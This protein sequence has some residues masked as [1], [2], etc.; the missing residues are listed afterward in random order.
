M[1]NGFY[2]PILKA[3]YGEFLA[4]SQLTPDIRKHI[5]PLLEITPK[6]W[7][8]EGKKKALSMEEHLVKI[9]LKF[10][11]YWP[12]D[13][14]FIDTALIC[15]EQADSSSCIEYLYKRF[16]ERGLRPIPVVALTSPAG[17]LA[18][19]QALRQKYTINDCALRV[20]ITEFSDPELNDK[21]LEFMSL[22]ALESR[23][24]HL[25]LDLAA[26]EFEDYEGFAE[27]ILGRLEHFPMLQNWK[28]FTVCGSALPSSGNIKDSINCIPRNEWNFYQS[29][30]EKIKLTDFRRELNYGDYSIVS[31][32]YFEFDPEKMTTSAK[33]KYTTRENY[34]I[35]KGKSLK[36]KG[37]GQYISQAQEIT[38][39]LYFEGEFFSAGDKHLK[40]CADKQT[41]T[42]NASIWNSVGNNHHI[43]RVVTDLFSSPLLTSYI[44]A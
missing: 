28:S 27:A 33:I 10:I 11:K 44:E 13:S 32:G 9:S 37:Y 24:M 41:K 8:H 18:G 1:E 3:K 15:Q 38:S 19:V 7:D 14:T 36:T 6:E 34:M 25:I 35:M 31:P 30:R 17:H 26:A 39:S 5:I 4:L 21:V 16:F 42:G 23:N 22:R 29:L 12:F 20:T 2:V 40:E 43:T